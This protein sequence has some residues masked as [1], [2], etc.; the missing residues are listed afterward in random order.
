MNDELMNAEKD[1]M[2]D[3]LMNAEK[4][5]KMN[6]VERWADERWADERRER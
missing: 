1:K 3:E 6:D 4:K 5:A 2:N